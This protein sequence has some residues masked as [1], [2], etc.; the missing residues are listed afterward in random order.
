[1]IRR[2][3]D[4]NVQAELLFSLHERCRIQSP[5]GA[6][7]YC[8]RFADSLESG[9]CIEVPLDVVIAMLG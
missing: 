8:H 2:I 5:A 1:M 3:P 6:N 7:A 4:R 9:T